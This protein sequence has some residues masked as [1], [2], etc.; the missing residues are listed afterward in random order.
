MSICLD[1]HVY[2]MTTRFLKL[3]TDEIIQ[4]IA[5][6]NLSMSSAGFFPDQLK[7]AKF[8]P[9]FKKSDKNEVNNSGISPF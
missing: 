9:I 6:I 1:V 7:L 3:I 2:G 4:P 8:T 5:K